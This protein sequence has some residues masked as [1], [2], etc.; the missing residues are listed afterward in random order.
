MSKNLERE[1]ALHCSPALCGI[2]PSNL[3]SLSIRDFDIDKEV[4]ELNKKFGPRICFRIMKKEEDRCLILI[5]RTKLLE[6]TLFNEDTMMFLKKEGYPYINDID[7][8]LDCLEIRMITNQ[9]FPHEIGV[10]LGYDLSD[11]LHFINK[12][13][14]CIHTGYWKVYSDLELKLEIFNRYTKCRDC[15]I[16][17]LNRGYSIENFMRV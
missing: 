1:F 10:F 2:K 6:K 12:D 7:T 17:L 15:V 5:Y 8:L 16:R 4:L 13:K 14:R 11:V 9:E 3:V